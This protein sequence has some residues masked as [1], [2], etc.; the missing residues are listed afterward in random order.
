MLRPATLQAGTKPPNCGNL[1]QDEHPDRVWQFFPLTPLH[2][3]P[4]RVAI[5][6]QCLHLRSHE[7]GNQQCNPKLEAHICILNLV[8]GELAQVSLTTSLW[9]SI[10]TKVSPGPCIKPG[11]LW[12][13]QTPLACWRNS[14]VTHRLVP[15]LRTSKPSPQQ[16]SLL[17]LNNMPLS[18]AEL[19]A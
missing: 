16:D 9:H 5:L 11:V 8:A 19:F 17:F 1:V 3:Y 2:P 18:A 14:C 4:T 7:M 15:S 12:T 6:T 10:L 13:G